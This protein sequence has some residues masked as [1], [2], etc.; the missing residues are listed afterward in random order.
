MDSTDYDAYFNRRWKQYSDA[1][2]V[3]PNALRN[4]FRIAVETLEIKKTDR[5]LNI[6]AAYNDISP[7]FTTK[8]TLYDCL[9]TSQS[10]AKNTGIPFTK[11]SSFPTNQNY[12]KIISLASLHHLNHL[13]RLA[14]FK[15]SYNHLDEGGM[16]VVGDVLLDSPQDIWLNSFVDTHNSYGHNGLFWTSNDCE[17][18]YMAGFN[19]VECVEKEYN[20]LFENKKDLLYFTRNIFGIDSPISDEEL[21]QALHSHFHMQDFSIPWKLLY[22]KASKASLTPFLS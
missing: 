3:C 14:F 15:E 4:E 9:E 8:P 6:P 12:T 17:L 21:F 18:F 16:L 19:H 2:L 20:W 1:C 10:F 11:W 22:F 13:E 7:Y 5:I